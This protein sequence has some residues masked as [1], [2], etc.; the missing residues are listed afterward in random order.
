MPDRGLPSRTSLAVR[1]VAIAA[2]L[3][4]AAAATIAHSGGAFSTDPVV[5]TTLPAS[6][7]PV[8]ANSP[9]Q[10]RGAVVG[11]LDSVHGEPD[12]S[13]LALRMDP[14][15][16]GQVPAN[17]EVRLLPRT[18]FGDQ[19][20]DLA[21]PEGES[22]SGSLA[23]GAVLPA[24]DSGRVVRLY[25]AYTRLYRLIDDLDPARLQAALTALADA[26]RGRGAELGG[27]IDRAAT[28][29]ADAAPLLDSLGEDVHAVA[30]LGRDLASAAPDLL[31]SLDNAV[32][33]SHTVVAERAS[34]SALLSAGIELTGASRRFLVDNAD[35]FVQLTHATGPLA[36]AFA[37]H[38]GAFG[39]TVDAANFFLDGGKR[40]F[41]TGRFRIAA[42]LTLDDPYP[43]TAADCPRYPGMA[44]PNCGATTPQRDRQPEERPPE[45]GTA[46]PVGGPREQETMRRLAP[47]LPDPRGTAG[48]TADQPPSAD[49]LSLLLGPMVRGNRVVVPG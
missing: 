46:G 37:R 32:A 23:D 41:A 43:Y 11:R 35:R 25:T 36:E 19:Y 22:P 33:L 20:V 42:A 6:A 48:D 18:V 12:R 13:W 7:G 44:G 49:L 39:D 47:L 40:V 14:A 9:V 30:S 17:V 5:T 1:G 31:R 2:T 15:S 38:P 29:S 27:M 3:V 16:I 34:L 45:G 10:F 4:T 26:L 8:R 24:D 21:V 28:L